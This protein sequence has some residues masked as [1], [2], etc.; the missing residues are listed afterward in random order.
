MNQQ[1]MNQQAAKQPAMQPTLARPI[2]DHGEAQQVI[3]HLSD[4]MD[5]LLGVVEEETKLVRSGRL[6]EVA[7]LEG[8]KTDLA[9]HYL[10]DTARLQASQPYLSKTVPGVLHV[11]RERH[12]TFRAMLQINLTVLATAHAVSEGIIRGLSQEVNRKSAP[13][14]YGASGRHTAPNARNAQPLTLS[15]SL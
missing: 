9:R 1:A 12:N 3:G 8:K 10:A 5:A 13:Q 2:G 14:T 4:V 7:R 11:L 6:S 15:R